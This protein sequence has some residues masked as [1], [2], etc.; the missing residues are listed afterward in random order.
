MYF[1]LQEVGPEGIV[2]ITIFC[3]VVIGLVIAIVVAIAHRLKK[4]IGTKSRETPN[5]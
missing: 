4:R 5:Q 3:T 2:V 1:L